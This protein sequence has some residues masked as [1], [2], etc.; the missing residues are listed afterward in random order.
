MASGC[1][2]GSGQGGSHDTGADSDTDTD[3]DTENDSD[4]DADGD[5]D[6]DTDAD[7][8]VDT[9]TASD[10]NVPGVWTPIWE[11]EEYGIYGIHGNQ[12][13]DI[14]AVGFAFDQA[15]GSIV[16]HFDTS[17]NPQF[18]MTAFAAGYMGHGFSIWFETLDTIYVGAA[19]G[20]LL[21]WFEEGEWSQ[22]TL[23]GDG[24]TRLWAD[25]E[26][27]L[28]IVTGDSLWGMDTS[29]KALTQLEG[30]PKCCKSIWGFGEG[31]LHVGTVKVGYADVWRYSDGEWI[32]MESGLAPY[33][34]W[35]SAPD[36]LFVRTGVGEIQH[37]DGM[38]WTVMDLPP[39]PGLQILDIW[40]FGPDDVYAVGWWGTILHYDGVE[41][42]QMDSGTDLHIWDIWGPDPSTVYAVG[43][44]V[45]ASDGVILR[46]VAP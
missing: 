9:L 20:G 1:W 6:T 39:I 37:F 28:F 40:G 18:E 35:G 13:G 11:S 16:V 46:Y 14:V 21:Q 33:L 12:V 10:T 19:M 38:T 15:G 17:S 2:L 8:D 31:Q 23:S 22:Q 42:T 4:S 34:L 29:T 24:T 45:G 43:G 5:G 25:S 32:P 26:N 7:T 41:W 36:D 44:V 27:N 3:G 30:P